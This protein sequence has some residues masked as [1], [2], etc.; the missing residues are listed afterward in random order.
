[1]EVAYF[2]FIP[3]ALAGVVTVYA[4]S[5]IT[6]FMRGCTAETQCKVLDVRHMVLL[7]VNVFVSWLYIVL[8]IRWNQVVTHDPDHML[9]ETGWRILESM[10]FALLIYWMRAFRE[11]YDCP[12]RPNARK[13]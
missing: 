4:V 2:D 11:R 10:Y 3:V 1:M 5:L 12:R 8:E 9:D 7:L 6:E 13:Q